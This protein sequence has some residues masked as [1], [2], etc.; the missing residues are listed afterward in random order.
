VRAE[1]A[2]ASFRFDP[3]AVLGFET[4]LRAVRKAHGDFFLLIGHSLLAA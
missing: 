4:E 2:R 3:F 1:Q